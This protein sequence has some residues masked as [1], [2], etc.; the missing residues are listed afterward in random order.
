[1]GAKH[2]LINGSEVRQSYSWITSHPKGGLRRTTLWRSGGFMLLSDRGS[3]QLELVGQLVADDGGR[4]R[5]KA[6]VD[7]HP[8]RRLVALAGLEAQRLNQRRGGSD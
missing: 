2:G 1:M 6:R 3:R 8:P 5:A 7:R 4:S